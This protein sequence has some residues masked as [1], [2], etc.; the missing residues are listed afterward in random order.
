MLY[1]LPMPQSHPHILGLITDLFFSSRVGST[2]QALGYSVEWIESSEVF[3]TPE[4]FLSHLL[5]TAPS[6][7]I[8]D[9]DAALPWADWLPAAK[10]DP[11]IA[12]IPWLAFGSH[13]DVASFARA[14]QASADRVLAR[15]KFTAELPQLIQGLAAGP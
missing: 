10:S 3:H 2:A 12:A 14:K 4:E 1:N 15:S 5:A 9:L 11:R 7:I 6:L 8:L 13:K